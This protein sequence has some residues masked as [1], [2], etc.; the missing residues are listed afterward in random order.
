MK[1][2]PH[3]LLFILCHT[4][5]MEFP[6]P[7]P[8]GPMRPNSVHLACV[9]SLIIS[10]QLH[11]ISKGKGCVLN[12]TELSIKE[13]VEDEKLRPWSYEHF[14]VWGILLHLS[15][16]IPHLPHQLLLRVLPHIDL[17]W[18]VQRPCQDLVF[19]A[20]QHKPCSHILTYNEPPGLTHI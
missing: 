14:L 4:M 7:C 10:T 9:T 12:P 15:P 1:V 18:E 19:E 2:Q 17:S 8:D 3:L 20:A 6:D 13:S 16:C 5:K 11:P